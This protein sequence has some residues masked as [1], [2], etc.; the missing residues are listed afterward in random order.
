MNNWSDYPI[1]L[2][3]AE[4]GNLTSAGKQLGMSQ[5][6]VGRRIKAL[7]IHFGTPL[8]TR[9][10]GKLI[11]TSFAHSMLDHIRRMDNEAS[12]INRSSAS[13][14]RSLAG[15]VRISVTEGVGTHWLPKAMQ[16]FRQSHPDIL[17]DID[18]SGTTSNL[19]QREADIALRWMGP[20]HQNSLIA[21]KTVSA[22]FAIYA[23]QS[24]AEKTDAPLHSISHIKDH[25]A[26]IYYPSQ[27]LELWPQ[28]EDEN[29]YPYKRL[30]FRSNN[31]MS[32]FHGVINGYGIGALPMTFVTPEMNLQRIF[33]DY[34]VNQE[35][36]W[37]VAHEDISKS[38]RIRAVFDFL[39]EALLKDRDYFAAKTQSQF[40]GY[41]FYYGAYTKPK[42]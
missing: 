7:E 42:I 2:A 31:L 18:V 8:F 14:E 28:D 26:V 27:E 1:F 35:D 19:A 5:P 20:G 32:H 24:Y 6:T 34:G 23:A 16:A 30:T 39:V 37:I 9:H 10:D 11:P 17:I 40:G 33:D 25:D 36:L 29:Y 3:V 38:V 12:A 4:S 22:S 15:P 13:L 21:R 41:P